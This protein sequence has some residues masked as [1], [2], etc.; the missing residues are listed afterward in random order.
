[1]KEGQVNAF[2]SNSIVSGFAEIVRAD[3][4]TIAR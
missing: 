4:R 3:V 2:V 1:M